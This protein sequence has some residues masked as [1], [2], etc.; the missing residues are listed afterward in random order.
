VPTR[1]RPRKARGF[2]NENDCMIKMVGYILNVDLFITYMKSYIYNNAYHVNYALHLYFRR[3]KYF[4][5]LH[6]AVSD[7]STK[8]KLQ[9]SRFSSN[10][11]TGTE[12]SPSQGMEQIN[13]IIS[14][15]FVCV[16]LF[17]S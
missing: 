12:S 15:E 3:K 4:S 17:V 5:A 13:K 14:I 9:Q 1:C 10:L 2:G 7:V 6:F 16:F 11:V 8:T